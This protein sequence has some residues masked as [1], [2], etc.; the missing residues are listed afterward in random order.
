[1]LRF[2]TVG[3]EVRMIS[4]GNVYEI[5]SNS[6]FAT[7]NFHYRQVTGALVSFYSHFQLIWSQMNDLSR[8]SIFG[9]WR[10]PSA[11]KPGPARATLSELFPFIADRSLVQIEI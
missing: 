10:S 8:N 1:M 2:L 9:E 7:A 5:S 11:L 4:M 3:M 6:S